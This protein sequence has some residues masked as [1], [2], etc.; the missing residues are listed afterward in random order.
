MSK[1]WIDDVNKAVFILESMLGELK[2]RKKNEF[3]G[4]NYTGLID[5]LEE[6]IELLVG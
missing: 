5:Q 3:A 1:I 4:G 2:R 6:A